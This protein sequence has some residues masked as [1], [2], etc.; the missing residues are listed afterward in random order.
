MRFKLKGCGEL[1]GAR[2]DFLFPGGNFLLG[3]DGLG[4]FCGRMFVKWWFLITSEVCEGVR[5]RRKRERE[6]ESERERERGS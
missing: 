2:C 5:E 3:E 1:K 4:D 6:R